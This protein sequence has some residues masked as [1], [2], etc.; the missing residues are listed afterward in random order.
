MPV[1]VL[2]NPVLPR[3]IPAV[4]RALTCGGSGR[5]NTG[6]GGACRECLVTGGT[7]H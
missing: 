7:G 6:G 2:T 4:I 3:S 5:C 1:G